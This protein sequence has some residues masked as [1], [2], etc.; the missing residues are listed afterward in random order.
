M[1]VLFS[2]KRAAL[3]AAPNY[4]PVYVSNHLDRRFYQRLV[5]SV[6]QTALIN[7][8]QLQPALT[9]FI[10]SRARTTSANTSSALATTGSNGS[11]TGTRAETRA[12][13]V[14][15]IPSIRAHSR[16]V[17]AS[18]FFRLALSPDPLRVV[19]GSPGRQGLRSGTENG[20]RPP[21]AC[22]AVQSGHL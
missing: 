9:S 10:A 22:C 11:L 19:P 14:V 6:N 17:H 4:L 12:G 8:D 16:L 20:R 3:R 18:R 7:S 5:D 15:E 21:E 1:L 2:M 13:T